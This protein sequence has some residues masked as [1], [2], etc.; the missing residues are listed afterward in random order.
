MPRSLVHSFPASVWER[1][2]FS[3]I[4][5]S[6]VSG[7]ALIPRILRSVLYCSGENVDIGRLDT[8][9]TSNKSQGLRCNVFR[10]GAWAQVLIL[11]ILCF[12]GCRSMTSHLESGRGAYF[13]G[14]LQTARTELSKV[15]KSRSPLAKTAK[16]DLALVEFASGD[17]KAA[18]TQLRESRDAFEEQ[19][20]LSVVGNAA[21]M[22]TDD[23]SRQFKPAGYELVMIRSML[24]LC[25]LAT[26]DGDAESYAMQA[27]VKQ[28]ELER[29]AQERG[30][31]LSHDVYQPLV[32]A[33]YMRG[34][35]R[36]ATH[37]DYDDALR[38]YQLVS[39]LQPS[40]APAAQDIERCGGGVHSAPN[41]GALYVFACVGRGPV[42]ESVEAPTTTAALQIATQVY[43]IAED[44]RAI[45]PNLASVK[46]PKVHVPYS[47]AAA[48]AIDSAGAL[49]GATQ[50]LVDIGDMAIRQN[51]VEMPWTIARAVVRRV[52]KEVTVSQTT[53]AVGIDGL[54]GELVRFAT[55]NL[56]SATEDADTRC[57]SLLAR[58]IQ[59]LRAE[60]PVGK[61]RVGF[62]VVGTD[63]R[64]IGP[65][66]TTE[67]QIDNAENCYVTIIA[68][69]NN[70]M[71]AGSN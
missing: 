17:A 25:S 1:N 66:S 44:Q 7:R 69:D 59:V 22:I 11:L 40:F 26:D 29:A 64:K 57:W 28:T 4:V 10:R 47:P 8:A 39:H 58:E 37:H 62:T 48:V 13:S 24:S 12:A 3:W 61:H 70:A 33:P 67:V 16:L 68:P 54:P 56:W 52:T 50:P 31:D 53:K 18:L 5:P 27:Q 6:S 49:L 9:V 55:V 19:L 63:G 32:L 20:D 36:E 43:S 45:L 65:R 46:V 34:V 60:L 42:L 30:I 35:L 71:I 41:H 23:R 2:A 14:D 51:E 21:A 15:A 38:S